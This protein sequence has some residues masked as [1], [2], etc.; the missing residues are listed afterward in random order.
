M[1]GCRD[2]RED[3]T[4]NG[5]RVKQFFGMQQNC[6]LLEFSGDQRGSSWKPPLLSF[7]LDAWVLWTPTRNRCT[8][9]D[10]CV[11]LSLPWSRGSEC[12]SAPATPTFFLHTHHNGR[13]NAL[14]ASTSLSSWCKGDRCVF[15]TL[16]STTVTYAQAKI[17]YEFKLA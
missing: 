7:F 13:R 17:W 10:T 3:E 1:A 14:D 11:F 5:Q 8:P 15:C 12:D 6:S 4:K 9:P 16:P 2:K